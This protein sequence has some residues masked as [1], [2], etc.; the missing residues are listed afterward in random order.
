MGSIDKSLTDIGFSSPLVI[1]DSA[2]IADVLP[3][4]RFCGIYVLHFVNNEYY[5]GKAVDIARRYQQ[6]HKTWGDIEKISVKKVDKLDLDGEEYRIINLLESYGYCLRNKELVSVLRGTSDFDTLMP[7]EEQ[8]MWL[9][10]LSYT[11]STKDRVQDDKLRKQYREDYRRF[12]EMPV[13]AAVTQVLREYVKLGIPAAPSTQKDFWS[14]SCLPKGTLPPLVRVNIFKQEVF[15]VGSQANEFHVR[16]F[17]AR[18]PLMAD[19]TGSFL[20]RPFTIVYSRFGF[21]KIRAKYFLNLGR[22]VG[23]LP[24]GGQDQI[25]LVVYGLDNALGFINEPIILSAIRLFNLNLMRKGHNLNF[26]SHCFDL[27]D[28]LFE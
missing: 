6:H 15:A 10:D 25:G 26:R 19:H 9:K 13:A 20:G 3:S 2:S 21:W 24:S 1:Q 23:T 14:C 18:S 7:P 12:E 11:F 28:R 16:I 4:K 27:A 5:V 17:L 22:T 8:E